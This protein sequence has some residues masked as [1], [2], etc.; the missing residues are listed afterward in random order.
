MF[1]PGLISV[2]QAFGFV[3][4]GFPDPDQY[5]ACEPNFKLV[6][7]EKTESFIIFFSKSALL[8]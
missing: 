8:M 2:I 3:F 1:T 6:K 4:N 5:S 7:N